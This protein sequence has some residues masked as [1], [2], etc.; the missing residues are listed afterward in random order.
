MLLADV[1][2]SYVTA[3]HTIRPTGDAAVGRTCDRLQAAAPR[4][5]IIIILLILIGVGAVALCE[6]QPRCCT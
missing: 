3:P 2:A 6:R 1:L 5:V 4:G